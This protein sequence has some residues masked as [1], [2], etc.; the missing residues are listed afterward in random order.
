MNT[1]SNGGT[2]TTT[3][4]VSERLDAL[5]IVLPKVTAPLAIYRPAV[6]TGSL[7]YVSGQVALRDGAVLHPGRLGAE[8]TTAQGKE[9]AR[10]CAINV[11][12]AVQDLRGNLEG[13]RVVRTV[14]YVACTPEFR[15]I[16]DVVNGASELLLDVL[17]AGP[18]VGTRLALGVTA[19]PANSPT[20]V[21]VIFEVR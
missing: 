10:Q 11:L 3:T 14:G 8:V 17:G 21:E 4:T 7:I 12:A 2:V 15:E 16:P 6:R 18:G 19:L 5:G 1:A 9:A 20:E 13:L